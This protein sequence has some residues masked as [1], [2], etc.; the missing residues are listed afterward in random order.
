M[1]VKMKLRPMLLMKLETGQ[2]AY[3]TWKWVGFK[4][5]RNKFAWLY[6][7]GNWDKK[8]QL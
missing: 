1:F 6:C 4:V 3:N 5:G 7:I 2:E 8:D